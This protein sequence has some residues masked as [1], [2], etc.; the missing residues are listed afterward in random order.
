MFQTFLDSKINSVYCVFYSDLE[1]F[2]LFETQI[3]V[4]HIF[5]MQLIII[6]AVV[7]DTF[8]CKDLLRG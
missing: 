6:K 5:C 4:I 1:R 7:K 8:D 2:N 3:L